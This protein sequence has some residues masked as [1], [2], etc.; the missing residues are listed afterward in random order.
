MMK[1]PLPP[2]IFCSQFITNV[3]EAFNSKYKKLG[4]TAVKK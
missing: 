2:G 3:D 1:S 4:A